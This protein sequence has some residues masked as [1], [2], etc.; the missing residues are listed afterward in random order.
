M[1]DLQSA[2]R[3]RRHLPRR[4][5]RP[6]LA[7]RHEH[8]DTGTTHLLA[9]AIEETGSTAS[10]LLEPIGVDTGRLRADLDRELAAPR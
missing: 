8:R 2:R 9:A 3:R 7:R 1:A 6:A 10:L 5:G 4:P